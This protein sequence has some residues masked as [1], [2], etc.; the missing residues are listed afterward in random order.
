MDELIDVFLDSIYESF[1][2]YFFSMFMIRNWY[3]VLFLFFYSLICFYTPYFIPILVYLQTSPHPLSPSFPPP[4]LQEDVTTP[5]PT[6]T[7]LHKLIV[8][9]SQKK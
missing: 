4:S 9:K 5:T 6:P 8:H 2:E 7:E 3:E 1:I